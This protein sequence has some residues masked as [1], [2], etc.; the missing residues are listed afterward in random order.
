MYKIPGIVS[1]IQK[2]KQV[3]SSE[4]VVTIGCQI[5]KNKNNPAL[6][7]CVCPQKDP[8]YVF[9]PYNNLDLPRRIKRRYK[10]SKEIQHGNSDNEDDFDLESGIPNKRISTNVE[11]MR[12]IK[13]VQRKEVGQDYIE[14]P[15]E[16]GSFWTDLANVVFG[17]V[18][19]PQAGRD[20]AGSRLLRRPWRRLND[21]GAVL[22]P[23]AKAGQ[24]FAGF[25]EGCL[26]QPDRARTC[27]HLHH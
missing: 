16:T 6:L 11:K 3:L 5:W 12:Q 19:H 24:P 21:H 27:R 13:T 2:K 18:E 10:K 7:K 1:L 9:D 22:C 15:Q 25:D 14:N 23:V 20:R 4:D 8:N 26:C 17:A